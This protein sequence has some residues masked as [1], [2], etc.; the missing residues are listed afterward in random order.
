MSKYRATFSKTMNG[1]LME[2][3]TDTES[4]ADRLLAFAIASGPISAALWRLVYAHEPEAHQELIKALS[5]KLNCDLK[6]AEL[7][8]SEFMQRQCMT[9]FGRKE[10]QI[11]NKVHIC[12]ACNGTGLYRHTDRSRAHYMKVSMAQAKKHAKVLRDLSNIL[13]TVDAELNRGMKRL[14]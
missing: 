9:C 1:S 5:D 14:L 10:M 12:G 6:I 8:I 11:D 7:S 13:G 3:E 4:N 2:N